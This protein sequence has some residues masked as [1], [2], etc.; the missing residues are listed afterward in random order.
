MSSEKK[1]FLATAPTAIQFLSFAVIAAG[2]LLLV[3]GGLL[4]AEIFQQDIFD[5]PLFQ[6]GLMAI[7][8]F[9]ITLS[10]IG[11]LK[12]N[13]VAW[14][15]FVCAALGILGGISLL[16]PEDLG[17]KFAIIIFSLILGDFLAENEFFLDVLTEEEEKMMMEA[18]IDPAEAPS[19]I[20]ILSSITM[21]LGAITAIAGVMS[22]EDFKV[23]EWSEEYLVDGKTTHIALLLIIVGVS[24]IISGFGLMRLMKPTY[25]LYLITVIVLITSLIYLYP[26]DRVPKTVIAIVAVLL[27]DLAAEKEFFFKPESVATPSRRKRRI[28]KIKEGETKKKAIA[29]PRPKPKSQP[30]TDKFRDREDLDELEHLEGEEHD[31]NEK[32]SKEKDEDWDTIEGKEWEGGDEEDLELLDDEEYDED[33]S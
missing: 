20:K 5:D 14:I 17:V 28:E 3:T 22:L 33:I 10:G 31:E 29:R 32:W 7:G 24:I 9:V 2:L 21:I 30:T 18:G 25:I 23:I 6:G 8:G 12:L 15:L 19:A 11:L 26:E 27:G 1:G 4:A 16:F 13:R